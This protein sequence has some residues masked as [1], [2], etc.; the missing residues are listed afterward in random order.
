MQI[1]RRASI[2]S[3]VKVKSSYSVG[4]SKLP[5]PVIVPN[6]FRY[7]EAAVGLGVAAVPLPCPLALWPPGASS[8]VGKRFW[9]PI[10][11]GLETYDLLNLVKDVVIGILKSF[12]A[13]ISRKGIGPPANTVLQYVITHAYSN[14][15]FNGAIQ[16]KGRAVGVQHNARAFM[17]TKFSLSFF[18]PFSV[19]IMYSIFGGRHMV[20]WCGVKSSLISNQLESHN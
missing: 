15:T 16:I 18:F 4:E 5:L 13:F 19:K 6:R 14:D 11:I 3:D 10:D 2:T 1:I 17:Q 9:E 20:Y 8:S 7:L 12:G